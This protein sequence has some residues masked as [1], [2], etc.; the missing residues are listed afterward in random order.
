MAAWNAAQ[1]VEPHR[2]ILAA[3]HKSIWIWCHRYHLIG[4][5]PIVTTEVVCLIDR[6]TIISGNWYAANWIGGEVNTCH[7]R[8]DD[9]T[10]AGAAN[11]AT[12]TVWE[13]FRWE[14]IAFVYG[15]VLEIDLRAERICKDEFLVVAAW[16]DL[17]TMLIPHDW[18]DTATVDI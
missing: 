10:I 16:Q 12:L 1:V 4:R 14:N 7:V 5:A 8:V 2:A 15:R 9:R 3:R 11:D 13:K 17:V 6:R 18:I